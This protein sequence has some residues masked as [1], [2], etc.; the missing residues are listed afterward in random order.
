MTIPV[1]CDRDTTF[2]STSDYNPGTKSKYN[3]TD[4]SP[5]VQVGIQYELGDEACAAVAN[6]ALVLYGIVTETDTSQLIDKSKV[7]R[8]KKTLFDKYRQLRDDY[9]REH[10][11]RIQ[12]DGKK[13]TGL[14]TKNIGGK[15]CVVKNRRNPT[16]P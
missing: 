11:T 1:T 5:I 2:D 9:A 7:R 14:G 8:A 13:D 15:N 6:A 4:I 12:M 16:S 10:L 3:T